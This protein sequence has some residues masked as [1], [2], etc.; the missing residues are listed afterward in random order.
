MSASSNSPGK[1]A[2]ASAVEGVGQVVVNTSDLNRFRTF[3]EGVLGLPHVISLSLAENPHLRYGVFAVGPAT[4]L[5]AFEV[6]G[7]DPATSSTGPIPTTST[8]SPAGPGRV[9]CMGRNGSKRAARDRCANQ[10][11]PA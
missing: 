4:A 6:P 2:I 10:G 7:C 3:Y 1:T 11:P 8:R 5:L 9:S